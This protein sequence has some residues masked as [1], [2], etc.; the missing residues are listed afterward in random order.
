MQIPP[1]RW[2]IL[3]NQASQNS[4]GLDIPFDRERLY[5][6]EVVKFMLVAKVSQICR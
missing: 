6:Q 1:A 4:T 2:E 5:S 3:P